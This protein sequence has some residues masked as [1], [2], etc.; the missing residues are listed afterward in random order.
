M[1]KNLSL[2]LI[3]WNVVLSAV[4]G[5][6]LLRGPQ[7]DASAEIS[8][9]EDV[10]TPVMV[11]RDSSALKDAR[12]AY[13]FMDSVQQRFEMVKEQGDRYRTEGRKLEGDLQNEMAKA[14]KRYQELMAKDQSYSTKT[15]ILEDEQELQ[16][17]VGKIQELQARSEERLA[18]MEMEMLSS[19]SGE[20]MDYLAEYNETA[21]FDYILSV[22]NG[23]QIWV[24]NKDLD[25]TQDV[26]E[27]LNRKHR[28]RKTTP[29]K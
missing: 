24:G 23:G 9:E 16:G 21:G 18:R 3:V 22:Q 6:S 26:I 14:Q 12:I 19:I 27:G 1:N 15:Q 10:P 28:A 7:A 5:W 11:E 8:A 29:K 20:I 17:L 2:L 4:L 13:F 25:V